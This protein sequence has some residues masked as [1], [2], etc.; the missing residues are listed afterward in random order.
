MTRQC[1]S[2]VVT[3]NTWLLFNPDDTAD[4]S[5]FTSTLACIRADG[6]DALAALRDGAS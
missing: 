4:F 3:A 1:F 2:A 6:N 5:I